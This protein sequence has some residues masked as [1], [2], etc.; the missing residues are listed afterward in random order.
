MKQNIWIFSLEKLETRYTAQWH[1]HIPELLKGRLTNYNV[2]QI[3]GIQKNTAVTEGAFLNFSDTNYWK[4]S[5]LCNFLERHNAGETTKDDHFL[6]T[7]A[8]NPTVIQLRYMSD[9]LG[10]NWKLHGLFHAGSWDPWDF[11]GR[12]VGEADWVTNTEKALFHA[13]D[14]NYFATDF[15]INMFI[16][17]RLKMEIDTARMHYMPTKKIVR[18]GWPMEYIADTLKDYNNLNKRNLILFPHRLAPEKQVEIFRDLAKELP[19]Y[20]WVVCQDQTL[21][22]DQ[23]HT[24]LGESKIVFSASKQETLGIS[25][26]FEG[27]LV[28]SLPLAP[29]R[30]SYSEIFDRYQEFMYPEEWTSSWDAYVENKEKLK[31]RIVMMMTNYESY[32]PILRSYNYSGIRQY[33]HAD[34]LISNF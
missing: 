7:D 18:T 26:G 22:K 2:I 6:F 24:L 30:L 14:H 33:A 32:I 8:W 34:E 13:Y 25:V 16:E 21:T 4:S 17:N 28:N 5:Q 10:F 23:Y 19:Q 31:S 29:N 3:D 1:S 11:L 9:L 15:H 12:I 20:D 27:P